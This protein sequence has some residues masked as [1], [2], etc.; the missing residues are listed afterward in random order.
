MRTEKKI[1]FFT[2][3]D[4]KAGQRVCF[5]DN[6]FVTG[7]AFNY[8]IVSKKR[9]SFII[10]GDELTEIKTSFYHDNLTHINVNLGDIMFVLS[11]N[12]VIAYRDQKYRLRFFS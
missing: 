6:T 12:G 1:E 5:R 7:S 2:K 9:Q 10:T 4:L 11:E 8:A 3:N